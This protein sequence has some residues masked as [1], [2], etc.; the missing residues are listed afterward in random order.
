MIVLGNDRPRNHPR[1]YR[2]GREDHTR[3][4]LQPLP[5]SAEKS[6]QL[7]GYSDGVAVRDEIIEPF[8]VLSPIGK[9]GCLDGTYSPV[10][11]LVHMQFVREIIEVTVELRY[12]LQIKL[13]QDGN[14]VVGAAGLLGFYVIGECLSCFVGLI[15]EEIM[16]GI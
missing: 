13:V 9:E 12:A 7:D 11:F 8:R 15:R 1:P 2:Q 6:D 10:A 4:L 3:F 16:P 14:A 5:G